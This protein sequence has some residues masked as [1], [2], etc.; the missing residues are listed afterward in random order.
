MPSWKKRLPL[1]IGLILLGMLGM[2]GV[3]HDITNIEAE[4]R[5]FEQLLERT[6]VVAHI[7]G[8]LSGLLYG[9]LLGWRRRLPPFRDMTDS[10]L[11]ACALLA[12][13]GAWI[14]AFRAH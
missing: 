8:F 11:G 5:R 1:V 10:L 2:G 14:L 3:S 7:T 13:L 12:I 6:D 9:A 4:S